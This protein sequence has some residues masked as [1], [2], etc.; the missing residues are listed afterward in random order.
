M[1]DGVELQAWGSWDFATRQGID[2]VR[3]RLNRPVS[4]LSGNWMD[5]DLIVS[6]PRRPFPTDMDFLGATYAVPWWLHRQ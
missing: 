2:Q 3:C 6:M 5:L 1:F 4:A